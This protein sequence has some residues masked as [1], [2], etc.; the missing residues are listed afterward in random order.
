MLTYVQLSEQEYVDFLVNLISS[1][2]GHLSVAT[3]TRDD[4]ITIGYG[5]TFA[6]GNNLALWQAAG[7]AL[8]PDEVTVLQSIDAATTLEQK[9]N[10]ALNQFTRSISKTEAT[11]LLRQ[12]YPEY[13]GPANQLAMP[14]SL[15]R[16]AF[17]SVSYNRG[18]RRPL[19]P[20]MQGF[21][22]AIRAQDRAEAWFQ[23]RYNS[24]GTATN[25]EAGL[26]ARRLVEAQVFNLY[27]FFNS[28]IGISAEESKQVYRMLQLHRVQILGDE[29]RWGVNPDGTA[30]TRNLIAEVN[31]DPRWSTL[32]RVQTLTETLSQ[33]QDAIIAWVNTQL[34]AGATPITA[35]M[36]DNAAAIYLDP[37]RDFATQP[38]DPN[39]DGVL[40]AREFSG[41]VEKTVKNVLIGEG[42][43]DFLTGGKGDDILI[44]GTGYDFYFWNTGDGNDRIIDDDR[45]GRIIINGQDGGD[46]FMGGYLQQINATTWQ[47]SDGLIT[48]THN[49]PWKLLLP[50]AAEVDLGDTLNSGDFGIVLGDTENTV[51]PTRT[52]AG[53][54]T[55]VDF[56]PNTA[57][58]QTQTDDLGNVITDSNQPEPNRADTLFDG[59]G[60]DL[61]QASGGDDVIDAFRGGADKIEGGAGRDKALAGDGDDIVEGGAGTDILYGGAGGDEVYANTKTTMSAA[62]T[63]GNIELASGLKGDWLSGGAGDDILVAGADND[64]LTGGAGID[65]LIG[66]AG[67]DNLIGDSDWIAQSFEWFYHDEP[68]A[69]GERAG[70]RVFEPVTGESNP[71]DD[72]ADTIYAGK[73]MD[74]IRGGR[75]DDVIYGEADDDNIGG[76]WGGDLIFGGS[77]NDQIAGDGVYIT[78]D[79]EHGDDYIDGGDGDDTLQG[80]GGADYLIGGAGADQ[81]FGDDSFVSAAFQGDDYLE[82][83]AGADVLDGGGGDDILVG[84]TE[85]DTLFGQAGNDTIEAGGGNDFVDGGEG[86]DTLLGEAGGDTLLT[87]A[88]NDYVEGG[89]GDDFIEGG[90]GNDTLIGGAG[91]DV[92]NGGG[93]NDIIVANFADGDFVIDGGG[94][95]SLQMLYEGDV[96]ALSI[97]QVFDVDGQAYLA[98]TDGVNQILIQS[99]FAGAVSQ[100]DFGGPT[101]VTRGDLMRQAQ[102]AALTLNGSAAGE[103]IIGGNSA[104]QITSGDGDDTVEGLGGNDAIDGGLGADTLQGGAGDDTYVVD[105][106]ADVVTESAGEGTDT[107][108]SAI[109]YTLGAEVENLVLTGAVA[110]NATGNALNNALTGNA[111]ANTMDGGAGNDTLAGGHGGDTY[112][113]G[114][115]YG[116]DAI[117]E[118]DD[119]FNPV[120]RVVFAADTLPADVA[121]SR[122]ADDLI[123]TIT[124]TTDTVT[125]AAYFTAPSAV[126]E[127]FHFDGGVVWNENTIAQMLSNGTQGDDFISGT[128]GNDVLNGLAGNDTL[129]GQ[130][131]NDRLFG[132][133][134][135]DTLNG[136]SGADILEGGLGNDFLNGGF[137]GDAYVFARGDGQDIIS[138]SDDGTNPVD[139]IEFAADILPADVTVRR[140]FSDLQLNI[141]GSSDRVTVSSYFFGDA[142]GPRVVEQIRLG[143][144]TIWDVAAIKALALA[145]TAGADT[146]TGY[147]SD[148]VINGAAG[149]DAIEGMGGND[150]LNGGDGNDNIGGGEG[151]DVIAGG[152]QNDTLRGNGGND[153]Y[154]YNLGD[155]SDTISNTDASTA[156]TDKLIF[157]PGITS[158]NLTVTRGGTPTDLLLLTSGGIVTLSGYFGTLGNANEVDEIRFTDDPATVWTVAGVRAMLLQANDFANTLVGYDTNDTIDGLGG[159][160]LIQG[161]DGNDTL[162]GGAGNDTITGGRGADILA[163]GAGDD[164]LY[165]E[166][167]SQDILA[168]QSGGDTLDGGTGRDQLFGRRGNDTYV[169]GRGYGHDSIDEATFFSDGLDTLRLNADVVPA[170]V[171]LYRHGDD[172]VVTIAGDPAQAWISQYYTLANKPIEQ[173]VFD[174]GTVWDAATIASLAITG[175]Q[176]AMT[177]TAGNDTF[178]VDHVGDTI[179]EGVNQ[180]TDT[181]QSGVSYN[182]PENVENIS[183]TGILDINSFGN[184][185]DN[186]MAG[187]AGDNQLGGSD[188]N[189]TLNGGAGHDTLFGDNGDDVLIGGAGND[190]LEGSTG[191]DT[192]AGGA[193]DDTYTLGSF[194]EFSSFDTVTEAAGEGEDTVIALLGSYTLAA[195]VENLVMGSNTFVQRTAIGNALDNTITIDF[196]GVVSSQVFLID[197][198][199]GADHMIGNSSADTY[200]VDN[201]GD[202]VFE[203]ATNPNPNPNGDTVRSSVTYTLTDNVENLEL[204]GT[205]ALSGTGNVLDNSLV[206]NGGANALSGLDGNDTLFGGAGIDTLMGGQGNDVYVLA[207]IR[208]VVSGTA[209]YGVNSLASINEDS[210]VEAVGEGID[211]V[212]TLFNYTLADNIENLELMSSTTGILVHALQ[213]TGNAL[214]NQITGN[215]ADNV[216]DGG[217]GADTMIGGQGNDTYYVDEAGDVVTELAGG[218]VADRVISQA[219]YTLGGEVENLTLAGAGAVS[220]TGNALANRLDGSQNSAANV[221][222]GGLA[223]DIYIVGDG[224]TIVENAGEGTDTVESSV[225]HA[226]G[227][228]VENLVLTGSAATTGTGDALDNR[229]DG[230]QN[231]A[232][233]T[234]AGGLGNDLYIVD[235]GDLIVENAGEGV[236][237]V[238]A[239]FSY[240]LGA[241][242]ENLTLTGAA[243]SATGSAD[244]NQ[245]TGNAF[246]NLIDG[247]AGAD[248]MSGGQGDDT[249]YVDDAGDVVS[250][251]AGGGTADT[252]I[253]QV[254]HTLGAEVENLVLAGSGAISGTGNAQGNTLD[255]MQNSAANVLAGGLGNDTY[256]LGDG[257]TIVENAGEGIDTV[258]SSSSFALAGEI[259]NLALVGAAA[260]DGT[261]N[262]LN[263][264]LS[265][266]GAANVLDGGGGADTLIGGAGDDTYRFAPGMGDDGI[267]EGDATAGNIDTLELGAGIAPADV[268]GSRVGDDLVLSFTGSSGTVT[269][270]SFY[271]SPDNETERV[272]FFGG[273]VWDIA[274]L[275]SIVAITGTSGADTLNGTSGDDRILG[276]GGND[277]L[278]GNAGNDFLDGGT[279]TDTMVGSTGDDTYVVDDPGDIVTESSSTGGI[280]TVLSSVT[281]TLV[282]NQENLTLTGTAAISGTGNTLNNILIGNVAANTLSGETGADSMTGGG[283]NDTYVV[284][285]V[286]DTATENLDEGTDTVQSSVTFTLG[287]NLENLT[288]TGTTAMN[289]TGNALDNMLTGNSA[290]NVLTG[291]AGNDTLDGGT[292]ADQ[293][294]GGIGD[295]TYVRDNTSDVITEN[296][297]EGIDTVQTSLAYTL[298]AN[299]EN[300]MLTGS[301]NIS[302]TGNALDNT[303]IGNAGRNTLTGGAGNDWLDGDTNRDTLAGGTG[304]D[305]YVVDQSSDSI[306]ENA[307]EGIDTVR[308]TLAWTLGSNLENLTLLGTA[309]INAIGN[310]LANALTGNSGNNTLT[311]N[312]GNDTLDGQAGSDTLIG[313]TGNDTYLLGRGHGAELVQENDTTAGNT[314]I[315]QFLENIAP[316]QIWFQQSGSDLVVS[317]IGTP[318]QFTVQNWYTGSQFRVEQFRT[319]DG[320]TLM[321]AQ[322][323]N[324]VDA[325]AAFSPPPPGQETLPPDYAAELNPTIA[326]NWQ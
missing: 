88:G 137:G 193:G 132:E 277:T 302:G 32:P 9:N 225:S 286:G 114:R 199:A 187:N 236:D 296:A 307:N 158:A 189:D 14:L 211:T 250:E 301:S 268:V 13:E 204:Q 188:G 220:G 141:N 93:G 24:W 91:V 160:D 130:A 147:A 120:D 63:A 23:M 22:D 159:D 10:I 74:W 186:T 129:F 232:A 235:G 145:G 280:D 260:I 322:V 213:G 222:A 103:H 66:G 19:E 169:F 297:N 317:I 121:V 203:S 251:L 47:S 200:V 166:E 276:L 126:V 266:N 72:G 98:L 246:G 218:G 85:S 162:L 133:L 81:I 298:A 197:G 55:P 310:T 254:S 60:D 237:S 69:P 201:A 76:E 217:A 15:E 315:G 30:G 284:D 257:D 38:I 243:V 181:I 77:G 151:D 208:A 71:P 110:I 50:G 44:G 86:D 289:G 238:T 57:G 89:D 94:T 142:V 291:A 51:T 157:G 259:E 258:Q 101:I 182:L 215:I 308:S 122:S 17:V 2:E 247:G 306:T 168:A 209:R 256:L 140:N 118:S 319:S 92:L 152:G 196:S 156:T 248:A 177:G 134:G 216:I 312:A 154:L 164:L 61:I 281:R 25:F 183:L 313:G 144:G 290:V 146:L 231:S 267:F 326:A 292:G 45:R 233:N 176:N 309:N 29:S 178:V 46:L 304:D 212:R 119:G 3:D 73:G 1:A 67:A 8:T 161:V 230:S 240:T 78:N 90:D 5:Y 221:L 205:G 234:L 288:L 97:S 40:N 295:D 135:T 108:Q 210:V 279:G 27:D 82:G 255:G 87:R 303:I 294:A 299:I 300:L 171:T 170:D 165:G 56:D 143:D 239:A 20:R 31:A 26:R 79:A 207:D 318:D 54:F 7:I 202:I 62:I 229:L 136:D 314:D 273:T 245:I 123:L 174:N 241:N 192:L 109:T 272:V 48:L 102:V 278:N 323:Q 21:F 95:N 226:L 80:N 172:L 269:L 195:N 194:S 275:K 185:L 49:S 64:V 206:G 261:G 270:N 153:T 167:Q 249:Y 179:T 262:A 224:D 320:Q 184:V 125:V 6:R 138:E 36:I 180:G 265:G 173:I 42:G 105:D 37:G 83:G 227:A 321:E 163:G 150:T 34:P 11:A 117:Q 107:V 148:D 35:V 58:V 111:A 128:A 68:P 223:N 274:T 285:N 12:T 305:T 127:E 41:G 175:T 99:G 282:T 4:Q 139:R 100:F 96:S 131:G 155:G 59:T 287:A 228:N 112:R 16:V 33:A 43:D 324:L 190:R 18:V 65:V 325:M 244:D 53:D 39:H 283:G 191:T 242:V 293:M 106:A 124:G 149:A 75:G 253:S 113:F 84:G 104:D 214:A 219:S 70:S 115:G 316:D 271:S 263:N 264:T 198:G 311:G 28:E 252:V 52:I 116:Q